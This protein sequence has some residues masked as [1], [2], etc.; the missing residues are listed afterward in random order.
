METFFKSLFDSLDK[1]ADILNV[2]RLIFYTSAGFC[3]LLPVAMLM[4][5]LAQGQPAPFWQQFKCDMR[6]SAWHVEVWVAALVFGFVIAAYCFVTVIQRLE[7]AV[8]E[9]PNEHTYAFHYARLFSGGV[10]PKELTDKDY[11]KDY[12]SWLISEYFRYIEIVVFIPFGILL[13]LPIY[14]VYALVYIIRTVP[15]ATVLTFGAPHMA[16]ALW[17]L[18]SV[19]GWAI[20]WPEYWIPHV[21]QEVKASWERA[22]RDAINGLIKFVEGSRPNIKENIRSNT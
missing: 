13:S 20:F 3:A 9:Q 21:V 8:E 16:F 15:T 6:S 5:M 4:R 14:A 17:T 12:A 10:G 7:A 18:L 1:T 2:G 22:R 11:R 19:I